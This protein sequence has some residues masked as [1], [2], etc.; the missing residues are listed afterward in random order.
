MKTLRVLMAAIFLSAMFVFSHQGFS[1]AHEEEHSKGDIQMLR[2]AAAALKITNPDLS[3][4]LSKYADREAKE[5][6][7]EAEEHEK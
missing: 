7:E 3:E 5:E 2:D 1:Y 6:S 4:K